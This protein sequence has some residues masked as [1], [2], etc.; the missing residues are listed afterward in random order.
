MDE[1]KKEISRNEDSALE[2]MQAIE[3]LSGELVDLEKGSCG[4]AGPIDGS[5]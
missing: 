3:D 4:S 5:R 2:L 1:T